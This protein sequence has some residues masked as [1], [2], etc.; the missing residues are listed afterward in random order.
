LEI[1]ESA[2][3]LCARSD[4]DAVVIGAETSL[5]ADMVELAAAAGKAIVLQKPMALSMEEADRIVAAVNEHKVPFTL[6]WQMRVDPQNQKMKE[7]RDGGTLGRLF[8]IRRRHG[9]SVHTWP[10]F[11]ESW[12]AQAKLN[13]GMFADDASHAIDFLLWFNGRPESVMSEVVTI[14]DPRV[15]DDNGIA[16]FKYADGTLAEITCSFTCIAGENTTELVFENGV[17]IQNFGD[18]PSCNAPRPPGGI[19]LK[20]FVKG[21]K[22]WTISDIASPPSHMERLKALAPEILKFLRGERPPIC[23][24]D[25]GRTSLAMTLA[26]YRSSELGRRVDIDELTQSR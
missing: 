1:V 4:I 9:L 18:L 26:C 8:M 15:P 7:L 11:H 3:A 12:H 19:G 17:V 10:N 22:E 24:V 14:N 16:V 21:D 13:K 20:W 5:H 2:K 25:E 23:T 6:A